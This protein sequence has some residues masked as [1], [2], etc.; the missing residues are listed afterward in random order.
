MR[1]DF[2]FCTELFVQRKCT[3]VPYLVFNTSSPGGGSIGFTQGWSHHGE[4][5]YLTNSLY[6][7]QGSEEEAQS[8]S[9]PFQLI[10][11]MCVPNLMVHRQEVLSPCTVLVFC[12]LMVHRQV[13]HAP[14]WPEWMSSRSTTPR[15][16]VWS[17]I[18]IGCQ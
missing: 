6:H 11:E 17:G 4:A 15:S 9:Q 1:L 18:L 14:F 16:S 8:N 13:L 10:K 7:H 3:H 5:E 2:L 12:H